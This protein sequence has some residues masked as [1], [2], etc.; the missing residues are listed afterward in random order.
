MD[1]QLTDAGTEAEQPELRRRRSRRRDGDGSDDWTGMFPAVTPDTTSAPVLPLRSSSWA[2]AAAA[3]DA[4][5]DAPP[6]PP[7]L[8]L[9]HI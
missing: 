2:E 3:A 1:N 9:I 6:A 4:V 5:S 7:A 8:S